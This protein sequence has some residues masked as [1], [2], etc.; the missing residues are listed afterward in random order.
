MAERRRGL[1]ARIGRARAR[2]AALDTAVFVFPLF[3]IYQLGIV[4]GGAGRNGADFVTAFLIELSARDLANYLWLL[5]ALLLGYAMLLGSLRRKGR[6]Q[7]NSFLPLLAESSVYAL[8]MGSLILL[9]MR[10]ALW[11]VPGLAAGV[12]VVRGPIDILVI[13]AG[14]GLHEEFIFRAGLMGGLAFALQGRLGRASAWGV[15]LL[16]S[17]LAFAAVHHLGPVGEEFTTGAFVYR[18]LAGAYFGVIYQW[19]GFAVAAWT[20]ALYDVFVLTFG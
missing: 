12:E 20:H 3:L 14:A 11:F 6:F 4:S 15:A 19:R 16:V 13:S 5:A 9:V 2:P 17:S 18:T 10:N 1:V 7:P 8:C